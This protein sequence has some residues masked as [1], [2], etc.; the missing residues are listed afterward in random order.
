MESTSPIEVRSQATGGQTPT[1]F[2]GGGHL[3]LDLLEPRTPLRFLIQRL[4]N[5]LNG[6]VDDEPDNGDEDGD[7]GD[8]DGRPDGRRRKRSR[9]EAGFEAARDLLRASMW[10]AHREDAAV[11]TIR[12][13]DHVDRVLM[14]AGPSN[15]TN[16]AP[17]SPSVEIEVAPM[18]E[19]TVRPF[20]SSRLAGETDVVAAPSPNEHDIMM[21]P[22]NAS[23]LVHSS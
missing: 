19:E 5:Q 20:S 16:S 23:E 2:R 8:D 21:V 7:D 3:I 18:P 14:A 1:N 6:P 15:L 9:N 17:A 4:N 13:E 12:P 11:G 10:N 22:P